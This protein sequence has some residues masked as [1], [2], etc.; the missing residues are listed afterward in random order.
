M[1]AEDL[2]GRLAAADAEI[3]RLRQ[4]GS[5]EMD[6]ANMR[7]AMARAEMSNNEMQAKMNEMQARMGKDLADAE[8]KHLQEQ[9]MVAK[10]RM[11]LSS[12]S[13]AAELMSRERDEALNLHK[14][15]R[16]LLIAM[17]ADRDA[18]V[19]DATGASVLP[20]GSPPPGIISPLLS[21]RYRCHPHCVIVI[22]I[23]G[24]VLIIVPQAH[25]WGTLHPISVRTLHQVPPL[26]PC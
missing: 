22:I 14:E 20:P 2:R 4:P 25:R 11:E 1:A 26:C 16:D 24:I 9:D 7:E 23:I 12:A 15:S 17:K 6:N 10:L 18:A 21:L 13:H 5:M 19:A 8:N 3:N